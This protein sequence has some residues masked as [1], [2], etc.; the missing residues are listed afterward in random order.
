[1]TERQERD[2]T[3]LMLDGRLDASTAPGFKQR[4]RELAGAGNVR[5][6]LDLSGVDFLDSSGLGVLVSALQQVGRKGGDVKISAPRPEMKS[7]FA[8]TRLNKIF[9]IHE[10]IQSA[11]SSYA[12]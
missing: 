10:N 5:F 12:G 1:M 2:V 7:L 8:L 9:E 4:F 6:V 11:L 3:L